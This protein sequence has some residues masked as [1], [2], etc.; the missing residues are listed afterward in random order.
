MAVFSFQLQPEICKPKT[1]S[2]GR[3][4]VSWSGSEKG[5]KG[6]QDAFA[7]PLLPTQRVGLPT[8][9]PCTAHTVVLPRANF[10]IFQLLGNRDELQLY[11][12]SSN[13]PLAES[14][15]VGPAPPVPPC[16]KHVCPAVARRLLFDASSGIRYRESLGEI[17]C[18]V[19]DLRAEYG[20]WPTTNQLKYR[21]GGAPSR[22]GSI[23]CRARHSAKP[24]QTCQES[25]E[26][27]RGVQSHPPPRHSCNVMVCSTWRMVQVSKNHELECHL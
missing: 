4:L 23:S 15:F 7:V 21:K 19:V 22:V 12:S 6:S 8:Y 20:S 3:R 2:R 14:C 27:N 18:A 5:H 26:L 1:N 11:R 13:T 16:C 9:G 10:E 24:P 17:S 25:A